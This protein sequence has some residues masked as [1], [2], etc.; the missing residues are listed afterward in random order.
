MPLEASEGKIAVS[1]FDGGESQSLQYSKTLRPLKA[2][3]PFP[4]IILGPCL[5]LVAIGRFMR[6]TRLVPSAAC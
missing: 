3:S 1:N 6:E 5:F 4:A 2:S